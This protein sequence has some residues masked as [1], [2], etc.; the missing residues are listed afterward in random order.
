MLHVWPVCVKDVSTGL[1]TLETSW[2]KFEKKKKTIGENCR[3]LLG[4][5]KQWHL[6][7]DKIH[8]CALYYE[9]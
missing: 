2:P 6:T 3:A 5:I 9:M 4:L 8:S 7:E 1:Q